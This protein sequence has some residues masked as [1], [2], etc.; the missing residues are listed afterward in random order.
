MALGFF[1]VDEQGNELLTPASIDR[2]RK[3]V[4]E[5]SKGASDTSPVKHWTVGAARLLDGLYA[6]MEDKRLNTKESDERKKSMAEFGQLTGMFTGGGAAP[7]AP[8]VPGQVTAPAST[9]GGV[10]SMGAAPGGGSGTPRGLRNNNPGNIEDGPFARGIPGYKGSDGRFAQF[11]TPEAGI[12]AQGRLIDTYNNKHGLNTV[13]GIIGRWAPASDGNNV[14]SYAATVAKSIGVDPNQPL[15]LADPNVKAALVGAMIQHE[16]GRNPFA[17]EQIAGAFSGQPVRT[18]VASLSPGIPAPGPAPVQSAPLPPPVDPNMPALPDWKGG[19]GAM[20][21]AP[22]PSADVLTP[23]PGMSATPGMGQVMPRGAYAQPV[24]PPSG[25]QAIAGALANPQAAQPAPVAPQRLAQAIQAPP[26]SP[27]A[28]TRNGVALAMQ[29]MQNPFADAGQKQVAA[30]ILQ[31]GLAGDEYGF[32]VVGD[33]LYRTDK[34]SGQAVPMGVTAAKPTY[35]VVSKDEFGN[36]QY[37]WI[38][39]GARTVTPVPGQRPAQPAPMAP[40]A[41]AAPANGAA[42]AAPA[43]IPPAPPGVDP[44]LWRSEQTKKLVNPDKFTETQ[45]N[46]NMFVSRMENAHEILNKTETEGLSAWNA[47]AGKIPIIGNYARSEN[48]KKY[49]QA[50]LAFVNSVL[51]KESG[52]SISPAEF[53]SADKQYFPQPDDPPSLIEQKRAARADAIETMKR[54][55]GPAYVPKA[56]TPEKPAAK[57]DGG[58]QEINGVKIRKVN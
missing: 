16:N 19:P 5:L 54:G 35:G 1:N 46:S 52:A 31:K 58:W 45:T 34:R 13:A 27:A 24:A 22:P 48:A 38:D 39:P 40:A 28:N 3:M 26:A 53:A 32:Q 12:A 29:I 56:A 36:E 6:G 17:R 14:S 10:P 37:G 33:Q 41:P 44:K 8:A 57:D 4:E 9:M 49:E 55:A 20:A 15:N 23:A 47:T 25:P 21:F 11:E 2:K 30:A 7:A 42:P 50:K 51:R 18:Q 43:G